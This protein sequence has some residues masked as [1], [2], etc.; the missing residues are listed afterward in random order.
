MRAYSL[1]PRPTARKPSSRAET[2][3]AIRNV[4]QHVARRLKTL[5]IISGR[6]QTDLG[7]ALGKTF[8]QMAK[9]ERGITKIAP[10]TLWLL[11][12][13]L[14][15]D[16]EYFFAD[17]DQPGADLHMTER[18]TTR[19]RLRQELVTALDRI[20]DDKLLRSLRVF[21]QATHGQDRD[22]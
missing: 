4:N 17:L 13:Y 22:E 21:L 1:S 11:A 5:R 3:N 9:Y 8:Q 12:E 15:V 16:I 14:Q 7:A 18:Q 10:G 19:R 2:A 6:T 20:A